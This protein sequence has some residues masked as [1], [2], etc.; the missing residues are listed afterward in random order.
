MKK[1]YSSAVTFL[2]FISQNCLAQL[3]PV[4]IINT[5]FNQDIVADG[6]GSNPLSV[7]STAI[8][9][10]AN[11]VLYTRE[12]I[13]ATEF[14]GGGLPNNGTIINGADTW[15]LQNYATNNAMFF[16]GATAGS[17]RNI[18]FTTPAAYSQL[19]LAAFA[20]NGSCNFS[21][22]VHY[23]D[24]TDGPLINT[25]VN[26]W[27]E[28]SPYIIN[29]LGRIS[30][31]S[32]VEGVSA[33]PNDPRIYQVNV[34]VNPAKNVQSITVTDNATDEGITLSI[35]AVSGLL[36]SALPVDLASFKGSYENNLKC[37]KLN[38]DAANTDGT[39]RFE[40]ERS[41]DGNLFNKLDDVQLM[42]SNIKSSFSYNDYSAVNTKTYYYRI[43][44]VQQSGQFVYTTVIKIVAG[45]TSAI[46]L[47]QSPGLISVMN[48]SQGSSEYTLM[49]GASILIRKGI[50]SASDPSIN[51]SLLVSGIY[52][53][54]VKSNSGY[55]TLR[56]IK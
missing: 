39:V 25:S 16:A 27:F 10:A 11:Y 38:W 51:I 34:A 49:N 22:V 12:F 45:K 18:S 44:Q 19:S 2:I 33:L 50:L 9:G 37:V 36:M 26:D 6:T 8:D 29:G 53:L 24:E 48:L 46:K 55:Q 7:T 43:K 52:I 5:S 30:R 42:S 1:L 35:V 17:S 3:S 21:L 54:T 14:S 31:S 4:S 40:I 41:S 32:F 28:N 47:L 15:Q 56:F 13:N 23:T 20:A